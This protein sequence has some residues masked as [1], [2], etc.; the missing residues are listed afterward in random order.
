MLKLSL[1]MV[2]IQYEGH[3]NKGN[4]GPSIWDTYTHGDPGITGIIK[5]SP[6]TVA[7]GGQE[8][9]IVHYIKLN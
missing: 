1:R 6:C 2:C 9:M 7:L 3:A 5:K 8:I 4:R